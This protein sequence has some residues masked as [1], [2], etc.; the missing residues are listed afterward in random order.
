MGIRFQCPNGHPLNVK[1][2]LAGRRGICPKCSAR[3]LVPV[4]SG[5]PA[6]PD[7]DQS[8]IEQA[9]Q[10]EP[11]E[12]VVTT[13]PLPRTTTPEAPDSTSLWYVRNDTDQQFGPVETD[14]IRQ[15]L[16]EGRVSSDSWVWRTGWPQWK[17]ADEAFAT[18]VH[19]PPVQTADESSMESAT[20]LTPPATP[21][22]GTPPVPQS[23][24]LTEPSRPDPPSVAHRKRIGQRKKRRVQL[25]LILTL[26][27]TLLFVGLIIVVLR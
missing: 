3:F 24:P 11:E 27:V 1:S 26:V 19:P 21:I 5:G 25:T 15:W 6:T 14:V 8:K 9:T 20:A 23:L 17:Q 4:T 2:Y 7:L 18:S 10:E 22:P 16:A 12:P 13:T